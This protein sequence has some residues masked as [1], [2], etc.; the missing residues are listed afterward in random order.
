M[1]RPFESL[2]PEEVLALAVHVERANA[3]RFRAFADVFELEHKL[4]A[5]G[6]QG[7]DS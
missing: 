4:Q 1:T 2:S 6:G 7:G 3:G 5:L